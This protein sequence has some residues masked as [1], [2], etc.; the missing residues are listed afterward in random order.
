MKSSTLFVSAAI[1]WLFLSPWSHSGVVRP[2]PDFSVRI[3]ENVKPLKGFQGQQ[4]VLLLADSPSTR[5]FRRQLKELE[6]AYDHFASSRVLFVVAFRNESAEPVASNI[7]FLNVSAG[8][9]A[10]ASYGLKSKFGIAIIGADGNLDYTTEQ[11]IHANRVREIL[12]NSYT[13]QEAARNR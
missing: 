13:V 9:A 11:E 5:A 1:A 12:Q 7:P 8:A 6:T 2:A 4:V 3:G 10:C